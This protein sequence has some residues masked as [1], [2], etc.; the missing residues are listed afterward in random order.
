M[1]INEIAAAIRKLRLDGE[2][3]KT[4][5]AAMSSGVES[6]PRTFMDQAILEACDIAHEAIDNALEDLRERLGPTV[7]D[8]VRAFRGIYREV[9]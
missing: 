5:L 6:L 8:D 4:I 1:R 9:A 3:A 2:E 7:E